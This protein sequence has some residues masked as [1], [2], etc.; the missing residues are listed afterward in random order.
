MLLEC[1][2]PA[3]VVIAL[4]SSASV[5][6]NRYSR[7]LEFTKD[8][9]YNLNIGP[10]RGDSR[11]GLETYAGNSLVR[12]NLNTFTTRRDAVNAISFIYMDGSTATSDALSTMRDM[13]DSNVGDRS[14][15]RNVGLVISDGHSNDR[16]ATQNEAQLTRAHGVTLL[17]IGVGMKTQ[18]DVTEMRLLASAAEAENFMVLEDLNNFENLTLRVLDAVCNSKF[19]Y[20][21]YIDNYICILL[22]FRNYDKETDHKCN[23]LLCCFRC[24]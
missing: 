18:Y 3:D 8:I 24:R 6:V 7:L 5:G 15:V 14:G 20:N 21:C 4:D 13:Y 1:H 2:E 22:F 10:G 19:K 11:V 17:S 23:I 9:V 12:Y 16:H